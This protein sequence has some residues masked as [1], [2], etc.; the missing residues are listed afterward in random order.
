MKRIFITM[1]VLALVCIAFAEPMASKWIGGSMII[2]PPTVKGTCY[3]V[4]SVTGASTNTGLDWDSPLATIDQAINKCAVGDTIYVDPNHMETYVAANGF[5][6]DVVG[7]T[8][9]FLGNNEKMGTL[10]FADTDATVAIGAEGVTVKGG[11]FLAGISAVVAGIMVEAAGDNFTLDGAIFPEPATNTFEFIDAIDVASGADG[12]TVK[13]CKYSHYGTTG[14]AHF[15]EMGNGVTLN[16]TFSNNNIIGEFSVAPIWSNDACL[17]VTIA[18]NAITNLTTG[19]FAIEFTAAATGV[20]SGN[21]L[22]TDSA[23]TALDPGSMK[24]FENYH[25][26]AVDVSGTLIPSAGSSSLEA[27]AARVVTMDANVSAIA[28]ALA[29]TDGIA[30]DIK[31]RLLT[32]DANVSAMATVAD[33]IAARI[34]TTDA[35]V[36]AA[37]ANAVLILADTGT[38]LPASLAIL[39][40]AS[41]P[42]YSNDNYLTVTADMTSAT[43]N[44]QAAHEI[45]NVT[46]A[47]RMRIIAY[48]VSTLTDAGNAGTITLGTAGNTA[49]MI[50]STDTDDLV[51][52]ELWNDA[53]PTSVE[54]EAAST[55]LLDFVICGGKD[56]GYTIGG[57]ALTGGS[58]IFH[59]WWTPLDATGAV[60]VGTGGVFAE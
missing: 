39:N 32:T 55:T 24:C 22:Y 44:T 54:M 49:G 37:A 17:D 46:G 52:T 6:A 14:P 59:I 11:K 20:C 43:W 19:Q 15:I 28:T 50:A 47:V 3:M 60:T 41:E 26:A 4:S 42:S 5:D 34:L 2:Y 30:D 38:T 12:L 33:T 31:A 10:V 29:V 27:V 16:A 35:N 8:I 21:L 51:S 18:N 36:S 53:S 40:A 9:I 13:N 25:T 45:A 7:I 56:V 58:I 48:C 1:I 23:S 57:E